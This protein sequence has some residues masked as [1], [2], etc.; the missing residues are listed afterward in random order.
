MY[1][2]AFSSCRDAEEY[3]GQRSRN[4]PPTKLM[5]SLRAACALHAHRFTEVAD[6]IDTTN[7]A[8]LINLASA[9]ANSGELKGMENT[10]E[11]LRQSLPRSH[12]YIVR[13]DLLEAL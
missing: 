1:D 12:P 10:L 13:L 3:L 7:P 6:L 11:F 4:R 2:D 9:Q 5:N 8:D